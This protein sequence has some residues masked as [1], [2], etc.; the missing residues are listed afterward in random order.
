MAK[1]NPLVEVFEKIFWTMNGRQKEG[2]TILITHRGAWNDTK[3]LALQDIASFDHGYLHLKVRDGEEKP[4]YGDEVLIP[5][6]RVMQVIDSRT[7]TVLYEKKG[8]I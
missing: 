3:E 2:I 5:F 8:S 6:H 4:E 7:G 1:K